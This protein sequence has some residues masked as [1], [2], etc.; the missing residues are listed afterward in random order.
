V[1]R[2]FLNEIV[3]LKQQEVA[4]LKKRFKKSDFIELGGRFP[5]VN[6]LQSSINAV[7]GVGIIAEIKKASPSKGLLREDFV[8]QKI[9]DI[10]QEEDVAG[11]SVLTEVH[12]FLGDPAYLESIAM[13]KVKPLLRKD[14]VIH[15]LQIYQSKALGADAVLLIAELLEPS[16]IAEYTHLANESGMD[17]LLELH[18]EDQLPKINF[19]VNTLIGINN[20]NLKTFETSL[21]TTKDIVRKIPSGVTAISE[22]GISTRDDVHRVRDLGVK[23]ILVGEHFMRAQDIRSEVKRFKEYCE[24]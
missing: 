14:F 16:Q 13:N 12:Y 4:G 22:S 18:S 3:E 19:T 5:K 7:S 9:A 2:N 10:Y 21:Q 20:R 24:D 6:S 1:S 8:P 17:I 23:G 11:I 15:E